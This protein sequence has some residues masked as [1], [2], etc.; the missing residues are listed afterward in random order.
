MRTDHLPCSVESM[1][2]V[3]DMIGFL[4]ACGVHTSFTFS[5]TNPDQIERI[6]IAH[7]ELEAE[8]YKPLSRLL[9]R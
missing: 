9:R 4:F 8:R 6:I 3:L 2:Q 1:H 5:P 7:E